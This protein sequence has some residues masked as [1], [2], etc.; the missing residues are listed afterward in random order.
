LICIVP[1]EYALEI[2]SLFVYLALL[3]N[4]AIRHG[5]ARQHHRTQDMTHVHALEKQRLIEKQNKNKGPKTWKSI[6]ARVDAK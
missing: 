1:Q 4:L 3:S 6:F 5:M 2:M